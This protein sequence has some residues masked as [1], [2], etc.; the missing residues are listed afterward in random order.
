M[1]RI[2]LIANDLKIRFDQALKTVKT[3]EIKCLKNQ[4]ANLKMNE[5]KIKSKGWMTWELKFSSLKNMKVKLRNRGLNIQKI[6][7]TNAKG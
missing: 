5:L 4:E 1:T 7:G 2:E 6:Q 3:A